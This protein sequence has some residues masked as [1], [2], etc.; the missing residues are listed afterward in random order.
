M[1]F[2]DTSQ[3]A[4][5]IHCQIQDFINEN[6]LR[7]IAVETL[8]ACNM[9]ASPAAY[10]YKT[11]KGMTWVSHFAASNKVLPNIRTVYHH[12]LARASVVTL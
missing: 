1:C 2:L 9:V 3:K 8:A 11:Q 7:N 5:C 10:I 6:A 12:V 4:I